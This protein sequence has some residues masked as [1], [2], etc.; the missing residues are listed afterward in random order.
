MM[1]FIILSVHIFNSFVNLNN[2]RYSQHCQDIHKPF[3]FVH[4]KDRGDNMNPSTWIKEVTLDQYPHIEQDIETDVLI[5]GAGLTGLSLGYYLSN[6]DAK[7]II[8]EA[9]HI[10]YGASGRNT[11]KISAQHGLLYDKLIKKHGYDIAKRYY[12][13]QIEAIDSIEEIIQEHKIEC[14]FM[15]CDSYLFTQE[16]TNLAALQDEYQA[17]LDLHIECEYIH[18]WDY[19]LPLKEGI[20]MHN[21]AK[22][23]PMKYMKAL[24]NILEQ[25]HQQIFEH[26]PVRTIIEKEDGYLALCNNRKIHAK[27]I[28]QAT[29]L[30][31]YDHHQ[32]YFSR[33]HPSMNS[34]AATSISTPLPEDMLIN[35]DNPL[36]S[37]NTIGQNQRKLIIGGNEHRVGQMIHHP[38]AFLHEAQKVFHIS[39]IDD[40]WTS[41]DYQS[42]DHLPMIGK[43]QKQND[44]LFIATAFNKWGNTT[45]NIAGKLLCAYLLHQ[46]SQYMDLFNPHRFTSIF[47]VNFVKENLDIAYEF[48]KSK[49]KDPDEEYPMINHG[50]VIMIDDH[51]YGVYRDE[52]EELFIVDIVCPHLG[53]NCVFNDID[54]TWDCP[55]H[56]SRYSYKGEIIKGPSTHKLNAYGEGLNIIDPH[57]L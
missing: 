31:F 25:R 15:R 38:D 23:H 34:M 26:S 24:A 53:C 22:F 21:Q 18:E 32:L 5:I 57:I 14:D 10:G 37:Y 35:I 50:K 47:A 42:F 6:S 7:F 17:C 40:T 46:E 13:S 1:I 43:L 16:E 4:T 3:F 27:R 2:K 29:Q 19:P 41:Q 51:P 44:H 30:P 54:K 20:R 48:I 8:V 33:I 28:V 45:S 12:T 9:N 56:A 11:C 52:H 49:F 55:C 39:T 36:K